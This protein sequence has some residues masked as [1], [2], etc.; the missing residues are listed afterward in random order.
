MDKPLSRSLTPHEFPNSKSRPLKPASTEYS[1]SSDAGD[2]GDAG[3]DPVAHQDQLSLLQLC[4]ALSFGLRWSHNFLLLATPSELSAWFGTKCGRP[5]HVLEP[6]ARFVTF[7]L[8]LG[9]ADT[10]S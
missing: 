2:A 8:G 9:L 6:H 1:W 10:S 7:K 3:F 4:V 5:L